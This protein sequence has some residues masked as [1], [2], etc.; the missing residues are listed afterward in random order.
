[1]GRTIST[2]KQLLP[3]WVYFC[4]KYQNVKKFGNNSKYLSHAKRM[5]ISAF[6]SLS[7]FNDNKFV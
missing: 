7:T 6:N 2:P 4:C 1:M 5:K 3:G